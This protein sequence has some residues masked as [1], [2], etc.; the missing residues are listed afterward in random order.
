[1]F[2][3]IEYFVEVLTLLQRKVKNIIKDKGKARA[4]GDLDRQQT[5]RAPCKCFRCGYVDNLIAKSPKP[6][7][8]N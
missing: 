6:P 5:E 8:D 4:T 2:R 7:K 3:Q 1:M